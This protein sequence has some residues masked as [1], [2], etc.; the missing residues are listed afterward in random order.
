MQ[1]ACNYIS[2][3]CVCVCVCFLLKTFLNRGR[4]PRLNQIPIINAWVTLNCCLQ[5]IIEIMR[6]DTIMAINAR[7]QEFWAQILAWSEHLA[8]EMVRPLFSPLALEPAV[9]MIIVAPRA[10]LVCLLSYVSATLFFFLRLIPV[11]LRVN[12]D[13]YKRLGKSRSLWLSGS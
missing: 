3:K 1:T 5:V 9:R 8:D 7:G 13:P 10:D 11:N 6:N 12:N 2:S 4:G